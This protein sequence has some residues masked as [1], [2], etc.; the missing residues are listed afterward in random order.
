MRPERI[1]VLT[2]RAVGTGGPDGDT[3]P[4]SVVAG[5]TVGEVVYAGATT[6]VV[7]VLDAG[8]ELVA[9]A[10]CR[11]GRRTRAGRGERVRLAWRPEDAYRLPSAPV[12]CP[13]RRA[14]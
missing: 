4:G 8:G 6:R 1:R 12:G 11:G 5:G 7:V 14:G 13:E 2:E 3:P 9:L 10:P